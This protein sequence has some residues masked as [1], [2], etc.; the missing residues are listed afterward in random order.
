V[1]L[2]PTA[3]CRY[4]RRLHAGT[5]LR[6]VCFGS[7][8][9]IDIGRL[10][11]LPH[12]AR[13]SEIVVGGCFAPGGI[14]PLAASESVRPRRLELHRG[15]T[16]DD[17]RRIERSAWAPGLGALTVGTR[18][19]RSGSETTSLLGALCGEAFLGLRELRLNEPFDGRLWDLEHQC[20]YFDFDILRDGKKTVRS[21]MGIIDNTGSGD[22]TS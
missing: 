14:A 6:R 7:R 19:P 9:A 10:V 5:P 2:N 15:V 12:F 22:E 13:L 17:V 18:L 4:G 11:G 3:Y 1:S 8:R 16:A 20:S 21:V